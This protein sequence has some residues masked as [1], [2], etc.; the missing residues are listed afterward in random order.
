VQAKVALDLCLGARPVGL[1]L[2]PTFGE[3]LEEDFSARWVHV[4]TSNA[5]AS[6]AV[7][8][9]FSLTLAFELTSLL[10]TA[11]KLTP[12]GSVV[13]VGSLVDACHGLS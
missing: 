7:N 4:T 2:S 3:D 8:E 12:A 6:N 13:P 1:D 11:W 9:V 10:W 5:V